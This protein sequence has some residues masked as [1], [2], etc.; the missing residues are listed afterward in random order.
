M[1]RFATLAALYVA[2]LIISELM[3]AKLVAVGPYVG[4]AA[5]IIYPFSFML[6]DVLAEL[7]GGAR[8][9]RV[10]WLG[11]AAL[12]VFVV[13]TALGTLL[14]AAPGTQAAG[15]AYDRV[16]GLVPRIVAG[17][18]TAYLVGE[19]L[20]VTIMAWLRNRRWF[21]A[22]TVLSTAVGQ[23][24]DSAMFITIAFAGLVPGAVLGRMVVT[25]YIAKV[26]IEAVFGTPLAYLFVRWVRRSPG[27]Q[28]AEDRLVS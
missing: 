15:A 10:V 12:F 14:P 18:L 27:K 28:E 21:G 5:V 13:W 22:R 2:A 4:P 11:F 17:S 25:Q 19:T 16:F 6:A 7:Y 9:R 3:A 26:L 23:L 24:F 1:P 8:T 20:N